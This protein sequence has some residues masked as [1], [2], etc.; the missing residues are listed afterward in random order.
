MRL[1]ILSGKQSAFINVV[2]WPETQPGTL[3]FRWPG[4]AI[5]CGSQLTVRDGQ[6]AVFFRD[7]KAMCTFG[8]GRHTLTTANLPLLDGLIHGLTGGV[9]LFTAEVYFLSQRV[10]VGLEWGTASAIDLA[11]SDLG[12]ASLKAGG[13]YSLRIADPLLFLHQFAGQHMHRIEALQHYLNGSVLAQFNSLLGNHRCTYA[14]SRAELRDFASALKVKVRHDFAKFG[15]EL[16]DL[17]I[18]DFSVHE[19]VG[20]A[21]RTRAEM[22]VLH[23]DSYLQYQV[24]NA[25]VAPASGGWNWPMQMGVGSMLFHLMARELGFG[26]PAWGYPPGPQVCICNQCRSTTHPGARFC[27]NCGYKLAPH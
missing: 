4:R 22:E 27:S 6:T 3:V 9:N 18:R 21:F 1:L 11:D 13:S 16:M 8:P 14:E 17:F 26:P 23:V 10:F 2:D 7:G 15:L 5:K 19:Q 20:Q 12:W 25:L 24:G